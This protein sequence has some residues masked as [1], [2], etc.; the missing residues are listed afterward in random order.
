MYK[1]AGTPLVIVALPER[2]ALALDVRCV[3]ILRKVIRFAVLLVVL[4]RVVVLFFVACGQRYALEHNENRHFD[5]PCVSP[6]P[7]LSFTSDSNWLRST[8]EP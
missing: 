2:D 8:C 7:G 6:L 1:Y 4:R 3:E 5:G